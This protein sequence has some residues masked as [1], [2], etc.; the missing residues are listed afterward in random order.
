MERAAG[1]NGPNLRFSQKLLM[2]I[3]HR[4]MVE[5]RS[6]EEGMMACADPVRALL[7][8]D[9]PADA[10]LTQCLLAESLG[11][12]KTHCA[13]RVSV[14]LRCLEHETFDVVILDLLLPDSVGLGGLRRIVQTSPEVPVVILSGVDD[15]DVKAEAFCEGAQEF[16]L[17][18]TKFEE[19][20][21]AV[22]RAISRKRAEAAL[23]RYAG[24]S[25]ANVIVGDDI[26][27]PARPAKILVIGY[28]SFDTVRRATEEY[29]HCFEVYEADSLGAARK[30]LIARSY[31]AVV[32][33]PDLPDAW[34]AHAYAT[35]SELTG[36][37]PVLLL[38]DGWNEVF[39]IP[40]QPSRP[41][42]E[43]RTAS[44]NTRQIRRLLISATLHKKTLEISS[45]TAR[46]DGAI[47]EPNSGGP[48]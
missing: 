42:C 16:L 18:G 36:S 43:V 20:G 24:R 9:N 47:A 3:A 35:L 21:R 10:T 27:S 15:E 8:E 44:A 6:Q 17:K 37:V 22:D 38:T 12:I 25:N 19:F 4:S 32:L 48:H 31:D 7:V 14:A 26:L 29:A 23:L 40:A 45:E 1:T 34:A 30:L 39:G 5:L 13:E 46:L 2:E 11:P 33:N 41:F 28:A